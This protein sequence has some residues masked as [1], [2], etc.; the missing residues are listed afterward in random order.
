MINNKKITVV[1]PAY[2]AGATLEETYNNIA[3]D[4]VDEI[5]LVDDCSIDNTVEVS[6]KLGIRTIRHEKNCGYGANQKTCYSEALKSGA[7]IVVMLHPD[8]QYDP[9]LIPA[10]ASMIAYDNYDCAI[11]S[12]FLVN[13]AKNSKMPKYKYIANRFLTTFQN[14]CLHKG[15]SEYHS[16]YRA[17]NRKVLENINL[18]SLDD[19]FI[20]DNQML[21]LIYYKGFS[22]G[23]ISC[24]T[25]YFDAASSI[26]FKR[27]MK[28]G[29]GVLWVSIQY[30][31][32]KSG[33]KLNPFN[34]R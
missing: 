21:A 13:S 25:K 11:A 24:P 6:E 26:N 10:L 4:I 14:I 2:N 17:F 29:F 32:A 22:I 8:F 34:Y 1:M 20:F 7:D 12:R 23:E 28:Y 16:G 19:D 3:L 18:S 31:L 33:I 27:S 15:L 9:R 5:I 30:I